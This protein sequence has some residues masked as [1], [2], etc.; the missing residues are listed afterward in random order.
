MITS[1]NFNVVSNTKIKH[2]PV[3]TITDKLSY[4]GEGDWEMTKDGLLSNSIGKGDS[5]AFSIENASN[6]V[7]S[8]DL[9]FKIHEGSASLIFRSNRDMNNKESYIAE[10]NVSTH[11]CKF[12]RWQ[13]NEV[14]QLIN[15]KEI[16]ATK[17]EKY[18]LKVVAYD[19]WILFYINEMLIA[20]TGDYV[21]QYDDKGQNTFIGDGVFGLLNKNT[22]VLFQNT[23]FKEINN[24]FNPL[25]K[26]IKITSSIGTVE[27]QSPFVS[28]EPIRIQYVDYNASTIKI[29]TSKMNDNAI[30]EI[31]DKDG[32]IY[33]EDEDIPVELGI[34]Y[35]SVKST[36]IS[37]DKKSA[38]V[39]YRMNVHRFKEDNI[40]YNEQYRDQYHFSLKE[41]WAN[42]PNG[43]VYYNGKYHL[44]FQFYD[45][46]QWGPMHW[47]HAISTDLLHWKEF[48]I[49]LYPDA[50]GA[51][52]SGS[53]VADIHN[54]SGL[55]KSDKGG[56]IAFISVDGNGQRVKLAYSEDE[57]ITWT[58][59]DKIIVDWTE[60]ELKSIDFRDPKV[61]H[62]ENKWFM[63]VAGGPLRLY[64][65]DNLID[66]EPESNY[67]DIDTECP[68]LYPIKADDGKI[69]W[70]LSRGGRY[71]KVGDLRKVNGKWTYLP[72]DEYKTKD[73]LMNFGKDSYAAMTYYIQ[74]FGTE[75][76]P[77]LPDIIELNWMN[78]WDDYAKIAAKKLEQ[79]F[80][81]TF[82]LNLKL[83]LK[84]EGDTYLLMQSPIKKYEELRITSEMKQWE[85]VTINKNNDLLNDFK[86]EKYEIIATFYPSK[87]TEKVGFRTRVGNDEETLI[88]YDVINEKIVIDRSI[89]GKMLSDIFKIVDSQAMKLNADG[90]IDMHIFVDRASVE[91]FAQDNTI[92]GANVIYPSLNSLGT[93]VIVEGEEVK[94]NITIYP[95]NGIWENQEK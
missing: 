32:K 52:F 83:D 41:G 24:N 90:S 33:K 77:T 67:P 92:I 64:S 87:S 21:L 7:Y 63:V 89:S 11:K 20:S 1:N 37:D 28:T 38:S 43:L 4:V 94:A 47:A 8:T 62:W 61:F 3:I 13:K 50:N 49:A 44:F 39:I 34:N 65:S 75:A 31:I 84:K 78:C 40:Y 59:L 68:D 25:L 51:M 48:P 71:Y 91:V 30:I 5:Y 17:N 72:D 10:I 23:Y 74:D 2:Y 73:G 22:K 85:N 76:N 9:T 35:I 95:L 26:D 86:S 15:E 46:L 54:D 58:K 45:D 29:N 14:L 36:I 19:S 27:D 55:F 12:Y 60:D 57:G 80:N 18:N 93:S 81:G 79:D 53:I 82:N 88:Y 69:K 56:L 16:E 70:V 6:F 66:W 42:D